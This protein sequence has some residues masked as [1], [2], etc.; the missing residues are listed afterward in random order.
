MDSLGCIENTGFETE[1][2]IFAKSRADIAFALRLEK[3]VKRSHL[4]FVVSAGANLLRNREAKLAITWVS[5]ADRR[6]CGD[7]ARDDR[8]LDCLPLCVTDCVR[9][10]LCE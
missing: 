8:S 1:A 9:A 6:K 5:V 7:H 10:R 4:R 2:E 3:I